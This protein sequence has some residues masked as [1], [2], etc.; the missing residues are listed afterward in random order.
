MMFTTWSRRPRALDQVEGLGPR[1]ADRPPPTELA[2]CAR[3]VM[4]AARRKPRGVP[5]EVLVA[6]GVDREPRRE[7]EA[8]GLQADDDR[9]LLVGRDHRV[10]DR[11][12][13]AD[14]GGE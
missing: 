11:A 5:A 2:L 7:L 12:K 14:R 9:A 8:H 10:G 13:P 3:Q 1:G 6:E 4:G